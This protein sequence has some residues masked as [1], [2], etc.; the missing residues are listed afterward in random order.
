MHTEKPNNDIC[1]LSIK[2]CDHNLT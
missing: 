1:L 2:H